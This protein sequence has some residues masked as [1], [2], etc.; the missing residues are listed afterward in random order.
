MTTPE[1]DRMAGST[2][3]RDYYEVL[4]VSKSASEEEIKKAY[5]KQAAKHHPDRNPGD[6]DAEAKF[7]ELST[8]Y[9]VISDPDKRQKYDRY[10]HAGGQADFPRGGSGTGGGGFPGAGQVD[11]GMAEE[12][13]RNMFGGGADVGDVFGGG[14]ARRG[15]SR[16]ART[17]APSPDIE[18]EVTVPFHDAANGGSIS[19]SVGGRSIDVRVPAG[20]EEGKKLRVPASATGAS[21]VLL[22]VKIAPHPYFKRDGNDITLEVPISIAEAVLGGRVEVPTL[23]GDRLTVKVPPGTSSGAK[24]RLKGKGIV[25]GDQFLVMKIV[26]PASLDE[27]SRELIEEFA[28]G[29]EFDARASVVWR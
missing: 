1:R 11:P 14:S 19:I 12:L 16:N 27:K 8:A 21:D 24:I 4:G 5:R 20:I 6:K 7:K 17:K 3:P 25:G 26:V 22:K 13:F 23:S 2:M 15:K 29:N 28:K 10:G 9:E 18:T